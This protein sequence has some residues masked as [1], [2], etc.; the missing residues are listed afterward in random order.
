MNKNLK[1]FIFTIILAFVLSL[2]L[3]WWSIMIAAFLSG[4]LIPLKKAAVFFV[5]FIAVALLWLVQS[6]LLSRANDFVLAKKIATLLMLEGNLTLLLIITGVV[7]GFAAGVSGLFSKQ[8][9]TITK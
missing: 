6:Y 2:Y 8:L 3:P 5:P 7:G 1:N 9:S 4:L